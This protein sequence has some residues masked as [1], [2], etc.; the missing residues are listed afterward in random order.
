LLL[1]LL[2][3]C[4]AAASVSLALRVP[5]LLFAGMQAWLL[6]C[7]VAAVIH[8]LFPRWQWTLF[9]TGTVLLVYLLG[10]EGLAPLAAFQPGALRFA[11]VL[12]LAFGCALC[13][14][15]NFA[16]AV[17]SRLQASALQP[18]LHLARVAFWACLAASG[19]VFLFL[20]T[21]SDF[22]AQ[23]GWPLL[24]LTA[25]LL[26]EPL[27]RLGVRFYQPKTL[28]E[29][30]APAGDSLLLDAL[31]GHGRGL[32][33]A[34]RRF[35]S[36]A[37]TK[38]RDM[39]MVQ[40]LRESFGIVLAAGLLLGWFSTCMTSV[41][42]G[43]R[44]VRMLFGRYQDRALEPGLHF[45][46]PWPFEQV[47]L[48]ETETVR[49]IFLGFDKDLQG[50]ILWNEPH[51]EGEKNLLV[52][53]GES[54]LTISVPILYRI[55]DP[56]AYLKTAKDVEEALAD[57]AERKLMLV[58][59]SRDSFN[60]MTDGREEIARGLKSALQGETDRFHLGI[61]VVYVGLKDVHPPVEVAPAYQEVVSA[62]E[63]KE[64]L[65]DQAGAY[66]AGALPEA[67]SEADRL[68]TLARAA[69]A[70][71]VALAAGE[72]ARFDAAVSAYKENPDLFL[73]RR[74]FDAIETALGKSTKTIVG[75][76]AEIPRQF[77]LDLR[78]SSDLPP[79]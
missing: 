78:N 9:F 77:Y 39:W 5:N 48:V 35:E 67:A 58:V 49:S 74:R 33:G 34:I 43:S 50:P 4:A 6:W 55:A 21:G 24:A 66:R 23:L 60:I 62:E 54:L 20:S 7:A 53:N 37:G 32:R 40:F 45:T 30:P 61:E 42:L 28:R 57:L 41:P 31:L 47:A 19:A 72:A 65:I 73:A 17:Q 26:L 76:P 11:A 27:A 2:L 29:A 18:V 44:G 46:L 3:A 63:E 14:F 12:F 71:R 1:A 69:G 59:G 16:A 79:P 15:A 36:L 75:L 56:V 68:K 52:G 25:L 70:S 10:K 51:A 38:I 64:T 13:F 8:H 22:S